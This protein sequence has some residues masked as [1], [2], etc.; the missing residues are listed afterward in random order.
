MAVFQNP[1]TGGKYTLTQLIWE[2]R[3]TAGFAGFFNTQL[4]LAFEGKPDA[5]ACIDSYLDPTDTELANLGIPEADWGPMRKCTD[6]GFLVVVTA[7]EEASR[8]P[9]ASAT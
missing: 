2:L 9:P 1:K 4:K 6:S 7:D 3:H 5:I 8:P